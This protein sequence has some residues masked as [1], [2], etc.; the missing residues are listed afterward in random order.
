MIIRLVRLICSC[1]IWLQLPLA[2][3]GQTP[4][5][6]SLL[7]QLPFQKNDS[8]KIAMLRD[9]GF[10]YYRTNAAKSANYLKEA[11]AL[12]QKT[13]NT[14]QHFGAWL[15]YAS[16]KIDMGQFDSATIILKR[17]LNEPFAAGNYRMRAA[18]LSN[19]ATVYLDQD[20]YL[21]AEQY[22]LKAID[23]YEKNNAPS[24]LVVASY[25]NICFVYTD[26]K[27][28]Q[29]AIKYANKLYGIAAKINDPASMVIALGFLSAS[30][31]RLGTP[32]KTLPL[33]NEALT[34]SL[35]QQNPNQRFE[36]YSDFGEYYIAVKQYD[37]AI[38]QL[39]KADSI[40]K[41]LTNNRHR[42]SNLA[43][44]GR[45][46]TLKGDYRN[47]RKILEQA[48]ALLTGDGKRN[49][50]RELYLALAEVEN[51]SGNDNSAYNYLYKY[52]GL[53]DTLYDA[54]TTAK[55]AELEIN[56]QTAKKEKDILQLQQETKNKTDSIH[57]S[58]TYTYI[59]LGSF[60]T[61]LLIS[62]LSYRTYKQKQLLQQQEIKQ[63]QSEKLLLATESILKGQEDERSR[64]AKDLHEGLGG[65]LSGV[66]LTL[67]AMKGNVLLSEENARLFTKAF[68]QLDSSIGEMRRVAHNMMP[69]ALVKLGLQQALQDY[70]DGI[71][72]TQALTINCEFH[73]LE[74]RLQNST[75]IIVYRILQEL[76]N[77]IIKHAHA[78]TVLVQVIRN[79]ALL[80]ITVEDNGHGFS[81][82]EARLKNGTGL[83]NIQSRVDYLKG[84]LDIRSEAGK[85]TSVL[86]SF[87][88]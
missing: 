2:I 68:E 88:V 19:L 32:E 84:E 71:S 18:A 27:Q 8:L 46:Y 10:D 78:G 36:V 87:A 30:Y 39:V 49:E 52:A 69:E 82:E 14:Y 7:K 37:K 65:M 3:C 51:K 63:L 81:N 16:L 42:G 34:L 59:L 47:A 73:G 40:A 70:C 50:R 77:N 80:N 55:I 60:V 35:K 33:L 12:A 22:Y 6:D 85:G 83:K 23:V 29:N 74:Q 31:T 4:V 58:R 72:Q 75:E 5:A 26:L 57:N 1:L 54:A 45:A 20:D 21:E 62:L 44:L 17:L 86:I 38:T 64:M 48:A 13:S 15:D 41:T 56:Y 11:I 61:L 9:I 79:N 43:L 67:G 25:G 76:I 53:K 24:E 28:Y 66:K